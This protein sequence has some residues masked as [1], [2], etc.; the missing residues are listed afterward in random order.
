S[1]PT[2]GSYTLSV[3]YSNG[4]TANRPADISVNGTVVA[5]GRAFPVTADWDTWADVSLTVTLVAGTNTIRVTG[6]TS[7]GPA[8]LD[9][10]E[11]T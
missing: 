4:T 9:Y 11:I 6:T 8:N 5:A 2:A 1:V 10:L 7:T 3:R